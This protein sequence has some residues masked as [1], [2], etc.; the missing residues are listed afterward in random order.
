M[1]GPDPG[2]A[3]AD[4][5]RCRRPF[6]AA[7]ADVHLVAPADARGVVRDLPG[8]PVSAS[9]LFDRLNGQ[10]TRAHLL[11]IA[12][13]DP[14]GAHLHFPILVKIRLSG[15][16]PP[17]LAFDP[18]EALRLTR[19]GSGDG[20]DHLARAWCCALMVIGPG[21][22]SDDLVDVAAQLVTSCLALGGDLP[23]LAERLFAWRAVSEEPAAAARGDR[24]PAEPADPVALLALLSLRAAA[25]PADPRLADLAGAV[26]DAFTAPD[27]PPDDRRGG[28]PGGPRG[29]PPGG[30]TTPLASTSAPHWRELIDAVLTPL[31]PTHSDVDRLVL[32]LGTDRS[33]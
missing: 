27:D 24:D 32:A 6:C 30:G 20:V 4:P 15:R 17:R 9:A 29:G 14:F 1:S 22:P 8:W 11:R 25:D 18:G 2:H 26:A 19:W 5:A 33:V 12:G 28:P 31:R 23:G 7:R 21:D 13:A 10:L 3:C 16:V